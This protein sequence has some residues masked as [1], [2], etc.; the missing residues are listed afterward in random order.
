MCEQ[1]EAKVAGAVA[2]GM[3][4]ENDPVYGDE[5]DAIFRIGVG[6]SEDRRHDAVRVHTD[7]RLHL[8]RWQASGNATVVPDVQEAIENLQAR[9]LLLTIFLV[10]AGV[11]IVLNV[12]AT[13]GLLLAYRRMARATSPSAI[14]PAESMVALPAPDTHS[15]TMSTALLT[16]PAATSGC[17]ASDSSLTSG[18]G[19]AQMAQVAHSL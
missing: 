15:D 16:L 13:L 18:M 17:D 11:L 19:V 6:R 5:R 1:T 14:A 9:C 3:F 4:T 10:I 12:C 7:G 2:L 8:R